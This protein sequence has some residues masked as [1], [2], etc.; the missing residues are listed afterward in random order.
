LE[1]I[2]RCGLKGRDTIAQQKAKIEESEIHPLLARL[3]VVC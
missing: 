3:S 1:T 2:L